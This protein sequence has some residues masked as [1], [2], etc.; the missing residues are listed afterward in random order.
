MRIEWLREVFD[1]C[2]AQGVPV[3]LKQYGTA[4][5]NPLWHTAPSGVS[6]SA[7]VNR[8]D[9]IGK[10]GSLLDGRSWKEFPA[11]ARAAAQ[12]RQAARCS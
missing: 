2:R 9:P 6:P 1:Q 7:W 11:A 12:Q 5:N 8:H 10:G 4:P 3:F